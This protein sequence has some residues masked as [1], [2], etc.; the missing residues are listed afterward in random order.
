MSIQ[1][2]IQ[3]FFSHTHIY[4]HTHVSII[5]KQSK[6]LETNNHFYFQL[7]ILHILRYLTQMESHSEFD[8]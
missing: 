7:M 5:L 8:C 3:I 6:T 2:H 1:I 4:T